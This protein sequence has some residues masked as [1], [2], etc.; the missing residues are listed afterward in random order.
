MGKVWNLQPVQKE[1]WAEEEGR[2][3]EN[4]WECAW[5]ARVEAGLWVSLESVCPCLLSARLQF[6][7]FP[8]FFMFCNLKEKE[9]IRARGCLKF[10]LSLG[11]Q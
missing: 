4:K 8:S 5:R 2:S 7:A 1:L 11:D 10:T 6:Q 3:L 9:K